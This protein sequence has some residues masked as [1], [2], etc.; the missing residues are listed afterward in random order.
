MKLQRY[1]QIVDLS[2]QV[3]NGA[4]DFGAIDKKLRDET[5]SMS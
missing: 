5:I 2:E 4:I 1:G 3:R